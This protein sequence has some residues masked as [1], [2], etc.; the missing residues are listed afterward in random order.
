MSNN[1][2]INK[3]LICNGTIKHDDYFNCAVNGDPENNRPGDI[4]YHETCFRDN[5]DNTEESLKEHLEKIIKSGHRLYDHNHPL[6]LEHLSESLNKLK[7][8]NIGY[9]VL[10]V[11]SRD[12]HHVF[13]VLTGNILK[14]LRKL[15]KKLVFINDYQKFDYASNRV[16]QLSIEG[17]ETC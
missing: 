7:N 15:G 12:G 13:E 3:C 17:D 11:D 4:P 5:V 10:R 2:L 16:I 8:P 9:E 1:N 14:G 6:A